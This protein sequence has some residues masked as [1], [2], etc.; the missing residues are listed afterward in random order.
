MSNCL[1]LSV[2]AQW[3]AINE[4]DE[5]FTPIH[6]YQVCNVMS[7]SQNNWLRTDWIPREGARRIYIEVKFT[8]R[9][10]NSMPG[11]LGTCK[12][13]FN[14]YYYES[15]RPAGSAIRE[16]QFIKIDTIAADESFT[17]VDL[18]VRR[19][20]LNTEVRSKVSNS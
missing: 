7:P 6:T 16:N 15:D 5:Y 20:K 13:T 1:F 17:G 10:C 19:L 2:S 11:V 8:L 14:L 4:M 12:E 3:D 18:G 9:D